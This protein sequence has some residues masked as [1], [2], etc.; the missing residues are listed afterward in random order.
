MLALRNEPY[1]P[2]MRHFLKGTMLF[3]G[4]GSMENF[5][6]PDGPAWFAFCIEDAK[7]W[8]RPTNMLLR[9]IAQGNSRV[10][11]YELLH[12]ISLVD[13]SKWGDHK[14]Y[15]SMLSSGVESPGMLNLAM[16]VK[17]QGHFGWVMRDEIMMV[18]PLKHLSFTKQVKLS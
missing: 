3:H 9:T 1:R 17:H 10:H 14:R 7:R 5:Q 8:I 13:L 18:E 6:V 11:C 2:P 12:D 4:T 16:A 15:R